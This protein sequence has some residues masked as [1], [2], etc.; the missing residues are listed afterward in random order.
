MEREK[1]TGT[2]E[3]FEEEASRLEPDISGFTRLCGSYEKAFV[4]SELSCDLE[5]PISAFIKLK[6]AFP[7]F[8][9]ESA[10]RGK[11]WGRY[12][13]LGFDPEKIIKCRGGLLT[14]STAGEEREIQGDP[15]QG[16]FREV[17]GERVFMGRD[18]VPFSGGAVGYFGYDILPHLESVELSG[19]GSGIPEM[20]FMFPRRIAVFDHLRST[21]LLGVLTGVPGDVDECQAVFSTAAGELEEM[22]GALR[23]PLQ[24]GLGEIHNPAAED[25]FERVRSNMSKEEY[26]GIVE[27]ARE[28]ILAGDAFQIVLSQK[29]TVPFEGDP[30]SIYRKLRSENPSPYM[31]Y[32]DLGPVKLVGSSPEPMVTQRGGKAMIRPIAGTRIRGGTDEED[33]E[34]EADL[35]SDPK[36]KA[37]HIMLV[38]LARND[39]GRVCRSGT[40]RVSRL[41][42]V[43]RYSHVMHIV[44]E[45]EGDLRDGSGNYDLL[46][47]SFPAGTVSG[48]PKVRA[49]RIIEELEKEGRGPYAGAVG[50]ISYSG[51]MDVCIT[52]RTVIISGGE[53]TVQAGAGIVAD[54]VPSHEYEETRN[55][56]RALVRALKAA[57]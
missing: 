37:E 29:F 54:S 52:I 23:S 50:Y 15:V 1:S 43:E 25:D 42:E 21:V 27:R 7:C 41:M 17:E 40:V 46:K 10:E 45:V 36:E 56:A 6:K 26:E 53:A 33:R 31:F 39:L 32:L 30:L 2:A 19:N 34:N 14:I 12:S 11:A 8:M 44:S 47:A 3:R 38:D 35:M 57:R 16:L 51:D 4:F 55:K 24:S 22:A 49:C 13:I 18:D 9:L 48:A 20:I 5:T 28:Y